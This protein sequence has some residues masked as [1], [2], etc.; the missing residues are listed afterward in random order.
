MPRATARF[1]LSEY[2]EKANGRFAN[3]VRRAALK[4]FLALEKAH[5]HSTRTPGA[6]PN[7]EHVEIYLY[8]WF[9]RTVS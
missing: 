5:V 2:T 1:S 8:T 6:Q 4:R 3:T 7:G 9:V